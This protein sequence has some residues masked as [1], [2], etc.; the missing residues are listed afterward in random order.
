M[1]E[2][3]AALT[4]FGFTISLQYRENSLAATLASPAKP[5]IEAP[6]PVGITKAPNFSPS[7][8]NFY[9]VTHILDQIT[10][11]LCLMAKIQTLHDR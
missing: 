7:V 4:T 11:L 6:I 1:P 3:Q 2:K 8:N 5:P 10:F 9:P